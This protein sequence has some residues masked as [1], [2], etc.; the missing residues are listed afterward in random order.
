[1]VNDKIK[2]FFD[3]Y[4]RVEYEKNE[5]VIFANSSIDTAYYIESGVVDMYDISEKGNRSI[6]NTFK[7]GAFFPMSNIINN[8]DSEYFFEARGKVI[9]RKAPAV[10]VI[11]LLKQNNDVLFDLLSRTYS[12]TDG[13]IS[14]IVELMQGDIGSRVMNELRINAARFGS[15]PT[16]DGDVLKHRITESELSERTGLARETVSRSIKKLIEDQKI[17]KYKGMFRILR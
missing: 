3:Q 16:D 13:L 8:I 1:M 4:T 7:T 10:D 14:K 2:M 17:D 9:I 15:E 6:I 11:K 5:V 12:G